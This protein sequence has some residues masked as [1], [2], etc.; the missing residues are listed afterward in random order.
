MNKDLIKYDLLNRLPNLIIEESQRGALCTLKVFVNV[1]T[2][3]DGADVVTKTLKCQKT[4]GNQDAVWEAIREDVLFA[5]YRE[6]DNKR[7]LLSL[8]NTQKDLIAK[9]VILLGQ[10]IFNIDT[11]KIEVYDGTV[12]V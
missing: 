2:K 4:M 3:V 7:L 11:K 8:T 12:W 10:M 9:G 5:E 6:I 1:T